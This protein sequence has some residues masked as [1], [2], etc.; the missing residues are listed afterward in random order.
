MTLTCDP[1]TWPTGGPGD[2]VR[3]DTC[4]KQL[5]SDDEIVECG[6]CDQRFCHDCYP[7]HAKEH[8]SL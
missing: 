5:P 8:Q 3:C 4:A 2:A 6:R 7:E 1:D